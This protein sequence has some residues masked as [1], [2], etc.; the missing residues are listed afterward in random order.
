LKNIPP[1][2]VMDRRPRRRPA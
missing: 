2:E 1:S